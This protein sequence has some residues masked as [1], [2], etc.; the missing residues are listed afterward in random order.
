MH[1]D[2]T[3]NL[4][5]ILTGAGLLIGLVAAHLQNQARL[6]AMHRQNSERLAHIETR[7]DMIYDWFIR[8]VVNRADAEQSSRPY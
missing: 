6:D 8:T 3:V 4:G 5:N 2:A 1:L 7:L